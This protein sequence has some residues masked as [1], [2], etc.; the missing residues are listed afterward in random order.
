[1][2][3]TGTPGLGKLTIVSVGTGGLPRRLER[4]SAGRTQNVTVALHALMSVMDDTRHSALAMMQ[5]MSDCPTPWRINSEIG[6]ARRRFPR[7]ATVPLPALRRAAGARLAGA[8]PRLKLSAEGSSRACARWTTRTASRSP[9]RSA[10]HGGGAAG[11][12]GAPARGRGAPARASPHSLVTPASIRVFTLAS[13]GKLRRCAGPHYVTLLDHHVA[14]G[15]PASA[16]R[17]ACR[18]AGSPGPR[19]LSRPRQAQI[20]VRIRR[21]EPFGR[22]VED[23]QLRIGHQ[24]AADREHLLL[25]AG[26]LVAHVG[27]ALGEARE[28]VVDAGSVHRASPCLAAAVSDQ[29]LLHGQSRKHIRPSGTSPS[30]RCAMR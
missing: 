3:S 17:D 28:E 2:G 1:M 20:S 16:R 26:K 6:S 13:A 12:G 9:T 23:E 25:A 4:A 10:A 18:P 11:E 8:E 30:P 5:W 22:L 14:V 15:D 21:R 19:F 27:A 29:V 24:C 7:R